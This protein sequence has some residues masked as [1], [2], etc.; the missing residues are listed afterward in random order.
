MVLEADRLGCADEV[1]VIAAALSIQDPRERPTEQ[2]AQAD[3][4]HSRFR[5]PSSDFL[6]YLNLWR[7]LRE[8]QRE[9][10]GSQFRKRC[11]AEFLH[12]L[13]V[14]EWQD[15]A[16]QLRT[17][18]KGAGVT[19]NRTPAEPDQ[20]HVALLSGLLSH[21][22]LRDPRRREFLGARGARFAIFPGSTLSR[23]QPTWVMVAELVETSRLFGRTAALIQPTWVEPLAEHLVKRTYSDPH[24]ERRRASVVATERVTLYGLPVVAG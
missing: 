20:I 3:E 13:R 4:A 18:A 9:L 11:K 19:I 24:W 6:A 1:V 5:D 8:Q 22:G 12:Y 23:R 14:R 15:L 10:S 7:Y 16:A 21:V 2:Q 17:A